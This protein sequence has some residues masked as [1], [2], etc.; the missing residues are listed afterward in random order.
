MTV[1]LIIRLGLDCQGEFIALINALQ[2]QIESGQPVQAV[3]GYLTTAMVAWAQ[4]RGVHERK[5]KLA[6]RLEKLT[7]RL[8]SRE[9]TR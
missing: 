7:R 9:P 1:Q 6:Q 5:L 3:V 2:M 8:F 4:A